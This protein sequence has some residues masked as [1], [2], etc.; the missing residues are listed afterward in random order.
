MK[1]FNVKAM[2]E[3][4]R[5][6]QAPVSLENVESHLRVGLLIALA[7]MSIF[8]TGI[9]KLHQKIRDIIKQKWY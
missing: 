3:E 5:S 2:N 4:V 6:S 8:N 1:F 7:I 9:V